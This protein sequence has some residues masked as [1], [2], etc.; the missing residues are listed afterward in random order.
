MPLAVD[1]KTKTPVLSSTLLPFFTWA[2][3]FSTSL[4]TW[5]EVTGSIEPGEFADLA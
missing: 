5:Y 1:V 2:I 3:G 4:L